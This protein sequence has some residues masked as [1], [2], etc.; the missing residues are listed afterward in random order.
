MKL[1]YAILSFIFIGIN[2]GHSHALWLETNT[3]G[4]LNKEQEIKVFFGEYSYNVI[5]EVNGK[6]F[7]NVKKFQLSLVNPSGE[8]TILETKEFKNYYSATYIPQENGVYT[9]E[10]INNEID[11]IDYTKYDF[12]IFKTHYHSMTKFTVGEE[13]STSKKLEYNGL[14]IQDITSS[15]GETLSFRV[16]YKGKELKDAEIEVAIAENWTKSIT[17][18]ENGVATLRLPWKNFNYFLEVT[19]KEEVPG[20]YNGEDYQFIWHCATYMYLN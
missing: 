17:T 14:Q 8:K 2:V 20:E 9:V 10:L 19:K 1:F 11:V 18:D 4:E 7:K 3:K 16:Y 6:A 15:E 5:E 12:G 13:L